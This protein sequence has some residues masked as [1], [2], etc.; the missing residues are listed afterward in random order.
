MSARGEFSSRIGFIMAAA[1]SAV[2]LGNIWG[3]PTNVAD[4]GGGA[5]VF[6]YIILTFL[7]AYPI[8]MAELT[9]GRYSRSNMVD[10]LAKISSGAKS[11]HA[12]HWVGTW[13]L[14]VASLILA[15]YS[16]VAGW[17][18][19]YGLE[20]VSSMLGLER[21]STWLTGFGTTRNIIFCA[22]FACLTVGIIRGGVSDGI[23]KWSTRLMP[24]L[25][26][27]I[28]LL[29]GYVATLEGASEGWR[30][31]LFPDFARTL[32]PDLLIAAMGQAFFSLSLGVGTMFIYG[33]YIPSDQNLPT[34][35]ASVTVVDIGVA[36]LAG[37]LVIPAMY[38]AQHNGVQIYS[39]SGEL[40][41]GDTLIFT[42][43]PALFETMGAA[44]NFV[45]IAFFALMT[46]AA[47][48]SSIS[49]LEVPV[50]Y[51]IE[52][53]D[54][55]RHGATW[56]VAGMIFLASCVIILNFD[57]LFGFVV[58]FTT[59]Y[60]EPMLGLLLCIFAGWVWRRDILLSELAQGHP[61]I[62]QSL[63][64]KIWPSYVRFVCPLLIALVFYQSVFG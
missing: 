49:M 42:V 8:L 53:Y 37:L 56:I 12:G 5:F 21:F 57:A 16:I 2:G 3:F 15:F 24:I 44:G 45:A 4:N 7:L 26:V 22:V 1:G 55:S 20:A 63:F 47:L 52:R 61:D 38:V 35:G 31:Y 43:L 51:A 14:I 28:V 10:G 18:L 34:L 39:E 64:W 17:M 62:E 25:L 11:R 40:L 23:E 6:V 29:I 58:D 50:C 48:T 59:R 19:A 36:I 54:I 30:V 9:I 32:N 41:A 33:S 46:I 27:I 60:S 13:A